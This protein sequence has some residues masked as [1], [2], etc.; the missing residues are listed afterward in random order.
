MHGYQIMNELRERTGGVW[1][2]AR[3]RSTRRCEML[4]DEGLVKSV[5]QDGRRVFEL[6]EAGTE[7]AAQAATEPTP[8]EA[9]AG[10][11]DAEAVEL[12]DLVGAGDR[13]RPLG[14]HA[15]EPA[16]IEQAK[17]VLRGRPQAAL[18]HP[19]R[20]LGRVT[21]PTVNNGARHRYSPTVARY[22]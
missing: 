12:R 10:E 4:Q 3:D 17:D 14:G 1:R 13:R 19:G 21:S 9:V 22:P 7:A 6:T 20:R 18:P 8:W 16:Q 15:G 2:P 5:D 11:G